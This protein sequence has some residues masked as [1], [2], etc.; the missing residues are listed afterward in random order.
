VHV[1]VKATEQL[2]RKH[3][4]SECHSAVSK[5]EYAP[6]RANCSFSWQ[7]GRVSLELDLIRDHKIKN[8]STFP[9]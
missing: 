6:S 5:E 9:L 2:L 1:V 4:A 8:K 7:P 3:D